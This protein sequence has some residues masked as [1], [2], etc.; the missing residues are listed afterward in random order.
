MNRPAI[1][2][3]IPAYNPDEVLIRI[4]RTLCRHFPLVVVNDGSNDEFIFTQLLAID[5]VTVLTHTTNRGKGAA[6]KTA[7]RYILDHYPDSAGIV[8]LDADGQHLPEDGLQVARHLRENPTS[9]IVGVRNFR[10][11]IPMRN[12]LGNLLTR[13]VM[14]IFLDVRLSDTQTGLRG[15]PMAALPHLISIPFD[16]YEFETEMLC[17][18]KKCGFAFDEIPIHTIYLNANQG[19]HFNPVL[20]SLL[21]YWTLLR[22]MLAG[23]VSAVVDFGVYLVTLTLSG[24]ILASVCLGR[25]SS[26]LINFLLVKH[27]TFRFRSYSRGARE[28]LLYLLQVIGMV[29]VTTYLVQMADSIFGIAPEVSKVPVDVLL[30]P[31]NFLIQKT[32]IFHTDHADETPDRTRVS[33]SQSD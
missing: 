29:F 6:L 7:F 9:L 10:G 31:I 25:L 33:V 32:I 17:M 4:V 11:N 30:Y 18:I 16:Q 22:H 28:F 13:S 19:S 23:I 15:I 24:H 14:R 12:R 5:G 3:V 26:L 2:G 27:F 20:D 1:I 8:A 21:I